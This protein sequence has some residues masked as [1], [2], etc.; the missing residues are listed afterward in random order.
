MSVKMKEFLEKY[1]SL[2][3]KNNPII[4]Q[5]G[6]NIS[7]QIFNSQID[8][9]TLDK[10]IQNTQSLQN[11]KV[12]V[13]HKRNI[14][15]YKYS[16][17]SIIK[18]QDLL[19]YH[20]YQIQASHREK[21]FHAVKYNIQSDN[22]IPPSNNEYETIEK[23]DIMTI[24]FNNQIDLIVNDYNSYYT[25]NIVIKKPVNTTFIIDILEKVFKYK[26]D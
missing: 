20:Q 9:Q 24:T 21:N 19:D 10:I 16:N 14:Q 13:N 23:Y 25:V 15:E 22:I 4:I 17:F 6:H 3:N 12:F 2:S 8:Q 1:A 5:Y 7:S 18:S 11:V 26:I